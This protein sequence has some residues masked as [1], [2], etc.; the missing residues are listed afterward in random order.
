MSTSQQRLSNNLSESSSPK[1]I[2]QTTLWCRDT[3]RGFT[4]TAEIFK[5]AERQEGSCSGS[6]SLPGREQ[7]FVI[8]RQTLIPQHNGTNQSLQQWSCV[9][10]KSRLPSNICLHNPHSQI[11]STFVLG[12]KTVWLHPGEDDMYSNICWLNAK[13]RDVSHYKYRQ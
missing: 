11:L 12:F 5:A 9:K 2:F 13:S 7:S 8:F 10:S 3:N 6:F 1:F 4:R